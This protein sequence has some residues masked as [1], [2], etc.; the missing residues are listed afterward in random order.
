MR[1]QKQNFFSKTL[2]L[3]ELYGVTDRYPGRILR[4]PMRGLVQ[5]ALPPA[6]I[7]QGGWSGWIHP[8]LPPAF[9]NKRRPS[10][11]DQPPAVAKAGLPN[12]LTTTISPSPPGSAQHRRA[13][14]LPLA[15]NPKVCSSTASSSTSA[16]K[17]SCSALCHGSSSNL[18]LTLPGCAFVDIV[19]DDASSQNRVTG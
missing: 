18:Q 4:G 17:T 12:I 2:R 8:D 7:S 5:F 15:Q 19:T 16:G 1:P 11:R 6:A 3:D 14:A 10:C 13:P 9:D